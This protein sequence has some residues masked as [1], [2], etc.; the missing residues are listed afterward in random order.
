MEK[1]NNNRISEIS[2]EFNILRLKVLMS[3][4]SS[5]QKMYGRH[6]KIQQEA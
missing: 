2:A 4:I 3:I 1:T 6:I 5:K